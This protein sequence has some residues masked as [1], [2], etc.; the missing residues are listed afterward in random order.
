MHYC[1][2]LFFKYILG[3]QYELHAATE[4]TP[5]VVVHVC[6]SNEEFE[7]EESMEVVKKPKP[8]IIKTRRPDYSPTNQSWTI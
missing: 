6:E 7:S 3:A 5:S 1:H 4:T 8:K 2:L